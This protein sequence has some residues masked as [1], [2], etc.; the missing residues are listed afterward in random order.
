M[1]EHVLCVS[2]YISGGTL[3]NWLA[4]HGAMQEEQARQAFKQM[5]SVVSHCHQKVSSWQTSP[6]HIKPVVLLGLLMSL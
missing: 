4:E 2:E 3:G 5:T 1:A 6:T